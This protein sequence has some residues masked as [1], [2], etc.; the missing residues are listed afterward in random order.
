MFFW[1]PAQLKRQRPNNANNTWSIQKTNSQSDLNTGVV[2]LGQAKRKSV[3]EY[4][5]RE[6]REYNKNDGES[7]KGKT[8]LR[9]CVVRHKKVIIA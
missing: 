6:S 9:R 4:F 7:K 1:D 2:E 5:E 3:R 8:N